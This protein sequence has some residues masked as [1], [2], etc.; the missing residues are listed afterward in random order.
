MNSWT[1]YLHKNKKNGKV[2]VGITSQNPNKRWKYG[3]GY[4]DQVFYKAIL[5]YGW[6]GFDHVIVKEG[7]P[8]Q[9]AKSLEKILIGWYKSNDSRFGYNVSSGGE[10]AVGIKRTKE[11]KD[12]LSAAHSIPVYQYSKDGKFIKE[13]TSAKEAGNSLGKTS[14]SKIGYCCKGMTKSAFGFMWSYTRKDRLNEYVNPSYIPVY[15]YDLDGNLINTFPSS[16][17]AARAIGLTSKDSSNIRRACKK[18]KCAYGF[19]WK[20][21]DE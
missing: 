7:L 16:T 8:E 17:D 2:Y 6:N 3:Y 21:K 4:V 9:C 15:Q 12:K 18:E 10:G 19:K 13:W 5:K 20:Y 1:V 11:V 14:Y